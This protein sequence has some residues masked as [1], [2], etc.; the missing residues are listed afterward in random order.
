[1]KN[2]LL[3]GIALLLFMSIFYQSN[4][5]IQTPVL[6]AAITSY[7]DTLHQD[8]QPV[9]FVVDQKKGFVYWLTFAGGLH[10]IRQD[11]NDHTYLNQKNDAW[12]DITFIEDF[13]VSETQ[14]RLYFTDLMD[15]QTGQSAIKVTDAEGKIE[16]VANLAHEIPYHISLSA[17]EEMLF[18]LSKTDIQGTPYFR[19]RFLDFKEGTK[20]T[21]YSSLSKIDSLSYDNTTQ[22]VNIR[23]KRQ[24]LFTFS[25]DLQKMMGLAE[26]FKHY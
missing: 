8:E 18:F 22:K 20:G 26:S 24:E 5:T 4:S 13:C 7:I 14:D 3:S 17:D 1:M 9:K 23:N 10:A 19:L 12:K 16:V 2:L 21:L 25:T 11:G 6:P 15:L